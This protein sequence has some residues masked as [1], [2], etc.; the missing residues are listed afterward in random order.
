MS[1]AE[2]QSRGADPCLASDGA[3]AGRLPAKQLAIALP[4]DRPKAD[5]GVPAKE[6]QRAVKRREAECPSHGKNDRFSGIMGE[7]RD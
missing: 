4:N 5:S 7:G 6:W 2:N 3:S 1:L